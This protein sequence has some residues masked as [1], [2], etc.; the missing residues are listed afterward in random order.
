M[1]SINATNNIPGTLKPTYQL[2]KNSPAGKKL[3]P[4]ERRSTAD[5]LFQWPK[6]LRKPLANLP[7]ASLGL[8]LAAQ[9][10][11]SLVQIGQEFAV[12]FLPRVLLNGGIRH[13]GKVILDEAAVE[14]PEY[15]A[16][17]LL[18]PLLGLGLA[19]ASQK[20]FTKQIPHF[21]L[22]GKRVKDLE[23]QI[24]KE[25]TIGTVK[26]SKVKIT[27]ELVNKVAF[28]KTFN[29]IAATLA[30]VA[31]EVAAVSSR[32]LTTNSVLKSNNFYDISGFKVDDSE[33]NDGDAAV[34]QAKLNIKYGL[35][36]IPTVLLGLFAAKA[37][38]SRTKLAQNKMFTGF[39]KRFDMGTGFGLSRLPLMAIMGAPLFAYTT[40]GR[41]LAE[42]LEN[43]YRIALFSIPTIIFY[44]PALGT[45]L[46]WAVSRYYGIK[47]PLKVEG[48]GIFGQWHDEV[49]GKNAGARD[50]LDIGFGK[51][52]KDPYTKEYSGA[53]PETPEAQAL[54][55]K[56]P[57]KYKRAMKNI[58][59]AKEWAPLLLFALPLGILISWINYQRTTKLHEHNQNNE[60]T[61]NLSFVDRI[62]DKLGH[63]SI[64]FQ[65]RN[66]DNYLKTANIYNASNGL[67]N[68]V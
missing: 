44:K 6:S 33:K 61:S 50:P 29:N 51:I 60:D 46:T 57:I 40:T 4:T 36:A 16:I 17:Y 20:L 25:I 13:S 22:L 58:Y 23:D 31:A 28:H 7:L 42:S 53:I 63:A 12:Q 10:G 1:S 26:Q 48:K 3:S 55:L 21:E 35:L 8:I 52:S 62:I 2:V 59:W 24:G 5:A 66:Y 56:D 64:N 45:F 14:V 15:G 43:W 65:Q 67:T 38:L 18:P 34:H 49:I 9:F 68:T 54:K 37:G 11:P 19:F 32:T 30:I 39:S 47:D 27:R 41:N